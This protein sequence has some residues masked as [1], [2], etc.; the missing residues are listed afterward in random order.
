MHVIYI[1]FNFRWSQF[2]FCRSNSNNSLSFSDAAM[3]LIHLANHC[4][5]RSSSGS[6]REANK[7]SVPDI[8]ERFSMAGNST[9]KQ[10]KIQILEYLVVLTRRWH[11]HHGGIEGYKQRCFF[12]SSVSISQFALNFLCPGYSTRLFSLAFVSSVRLFV[13][14]LFITWFP[15]FRESGISLVS[16]TNF[17]A[18][19]QLK[20]FSLLTS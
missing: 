7:E 15:R 8:R 4:L 12:H 1:W 19:N 18:C 13:A 9:D 2:I 20:T 6:R 5:L 10:M 14:D 3:N 16:S 11:F 17:A